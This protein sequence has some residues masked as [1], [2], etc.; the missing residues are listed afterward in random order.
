[1][2]KNV[3][4]TWAEQSSGKSAIIL[5]T[6]NMLLGHHEKVGFFRPIVS[7]KVDEDALITLVNSRFKLQNV[8]SGCS[9]SRAQEFI[10]ESQYDELIKEIL[11]EY[12]K[13]EEECDVIL[14]V[15]TDYLL[16][17][18]S[19][20]FEFNIDMANNLNASLI[21]IIKG[22]ERDVDEI[23]RAVES[24]HYTL[25]NEEC[26]V[27]AYVVNRVPSKLIDTL[28]QSISLE[29]APLYFIENDETLSYA[30]V[31]DIATFLDAKLLYG[32]K[33]LYAK[34]VVGFKV[35]AMRLPSFLKRVEKGDCIITPSDRVDIILGALLSFPST[36]YEEISA[37]VL[38][39]DE[40]IP[41]SV[42]DLIEGLRRI[43][44]PILKVEDDT[45]TTATKLDGI[46][47][48]MHP[49]NSSKIARAIGLVERSVDFHSLQTK[50]FKSVKREKMT[51]IMFEYELLHRAKS[52]KKHIVL[53]EGDEAR[54]LRAAEILLLRDVVEITLLGNVE[55]VEARI[56][57][58]NLDL[59]KAHIVATSPLRKEFAKE[60]V[61]L[62]KHKNVTLDH[63]YDNME[64]VSYFGTMMVHLGYADGMVSGA[65]HTTQATVRPALQIIKTKADVSIVSSVF[66]MCLKDRV[67]VYG[68]CAINPNPNAEE[69][70]D[71]A[72]S[73]A[74]TAAQFG[75]DVRVAMLSYSTGGSGKGDMVDK[76][77]KATQLAQQKAP[78]L[79]IEGPMQY[80]AAIDRSVAKTKLP[81]SKVAGRATLFIFPDLN[82]GNNTYKAVQRSAGALAI[83][84]ILQGL[85][86]PINDL[87]RGC[88]VD[89]IVNTI[90]I[91]AIQAQG[92]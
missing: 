50:L 57:A 82:T 40:P 49:E 27:L 31:G 42:Q 16:Q 59:R 83:G 30:S 67:L 23:S 28:A 41:Q 21:P 15:G 9:M 22:Y 44:V 78:E 45:F 61:K 58:L 13:L 90:A 29:D 39:G 77:A 6:L 52:N 20:E 35:A 85:N 36:A 73:S 38:T 74:K 7:S 11:Q 56:K 51:P 2:K 63:A 46:E 65:V 47:V 76:V 10:K 34:D 81:D 69:L 72:L 17:A 89:D 43:D 19:L 68:D 32:S 3:Y 37:I 84:P 33:E 26:D 24:M 92:E 14:C 87:S 18:E 25:K 80:D 86:R 79:L 70:C 66:F 12:K 91:T 48:R 60:F 88:S 64:D 75:I 53:P 1:V 62:R 71:I 55:R 4:I 5:A 54:T 8:A